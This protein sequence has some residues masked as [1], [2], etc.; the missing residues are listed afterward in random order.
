ML[1]GSAEAT[2]LY[3]YDNLD[4]VIQAVESNGTTTQYTY[5]ANGNVTSITRTAG[6]KVLSIGSVSANAGAVGSAPVGRPLSRSE[7]RRRG[8]ST[9]PCDGKLP[10]VKV[11]PVQISRLG[12]NSLRI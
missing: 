6:T 12:N 4:P 2:A 5:D 7:S 10:G 8:M 3:T 11:S 9:A 1:S